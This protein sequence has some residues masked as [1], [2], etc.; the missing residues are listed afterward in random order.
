ME[1]YLPDITQYASILIASSLILFFVGR[2][3]MLLLPEW[4]EKDNAYQ[5]VFNSFLLGYIIVLPLFAIVW[6]RANSIFW[7]VV[8]ICFLYL[9]WW[10]KPQKK[11][12][13]IDWRAEGCVLGIAMLLLLGGFALLYYFCLARSEGQM[14]S[15]QIYYSNLAQSI[16]S[17]HNE[18]YFRTTESIAQAYH[19]GESW[20]TAMWAWMF[21]AKPIYI[22]YGVTYPFLLVMCIL[23]VMAI[24]KQFDKSLPMAICLIAGILYF[25]QWNLTSLVTPWGCGGSV[26]AFKS[27]LM[28]LFALWGTAYIIQGKYSQGIFAALLSVAFYSPLAPGI[29]TL[30]C[31]LSYFMPDRPNLSV[32]QLFNPYV[33]GSLLLTIA[34][35]TFYVIQPNIYAAE[36]VF[37]HADH[38][39]QW[40]IGFIF[41]RVCRPIAGMTPIAVLL[42]IYLYIVNKEQLKKYVVFY[43]CVLVSCFVACVVAG[44]AT[45]VDVNAGQ[46]AENYYEMISHL[47]VYISMIFLLAELAKKHWKSICAIAIIAGL[48]YPGRYFYLGAKSVMAPIAP[49]TQSEKEA[50]VT[51]KNIFE[52]QPVYEMGYFRNYNLPENYNT[53]K[54]Q[55]DLFFPMDR[56]VHILPNG[57]HPYCLSAYD[58][59]DDIDPLWKDNMECELSQ[60]G[61]KRKL[62]KPD[63]TEEEIISEFITQTN[64]NYIIVENGAKLPDYLATRFCQVYEWEGNSL[65][66]R[67]D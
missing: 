11:D 34:Y 17:Y 33:L 67:L 18:A 63:I 56:L 25:F 52:I 65:Y 44:I 38:S 28:I 20:T 61:C 64:I 41:K 24:A 32:R 45:K 12:L 51:M 29:L 1:F 60:Y 39:M 50:Y 66:H 55:Y 2:G 21:G 9:S 22:L 37:N 27:Y 62:C 53:P 54:T 8:I 13:T 47:F 43:C 3:V 42:G 6:S 31:L 35:V 23:G 10:R 26:F 46:I 58:M 40:I 48:A 14:F 16:L 4:R 59:P 19:W 57:Y 49:M 7:L 36:T 30:V 15:D 5:T